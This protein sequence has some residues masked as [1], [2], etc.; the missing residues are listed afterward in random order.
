M[1]GDSTR[2]WGG[3][4]GAL[5]LDRRFAIAGSVVTLIGMIAV[6]A[7]VNRQIEIGVTRNSAIST[8]IYMESFIA[9]LSQELAHANTLAPETVAQ[10]GQLF[11]SPPLSGRIVSAKIWKPGGLVVFASD[12]ELIGERF[13]PTESLKKAWGGEISASFD[14]IEDEEAEGE[15]AIGL[16]LL[17][18]YNPI[19]SILTGEI[20]AVAEFYQ[21]AV[22]LKEDLFMAQLKSWGVVG[23]VTLLTFAALFGIVRNG[24][25]TIEAQNRELQHRLA[26]VD[27]MSAQNDVLRRRI[28]AASQRAAETNERVMRRLSAELHDGPAQ[29]MALA[30]LRLESLA[31]R[32]GAGAD[33]PDNAELRRSLDE[34][35]RDIRHICRGMTL[36]ELEGRTLAE[37]LQSAIT[38][39]ERRTDTRVSRTFTGADIALPHATLI[40]AYRFVQEGLMNAFRHAG[41]AAQSVSCLVA[42]D[43]LTLTVSDGGE[44]FDTKDGAEGGGLGLS[45]LKERVEASGGEFHIAT[46]A[47]GTTLTMMLNLEAVS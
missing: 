3:R 36:P 1:D 17:E 6:G 40:C 4:L 31:R 13:A 42:G 35:M 18:V 21:N 22:A 14:D 15:R 7:W 8:A 47:D 24:S 19:H 41:A 44:G 30:S 32:A 45:G 26:E 16:P 37:A 29:A 33:D 23:G 39:H 11:A 5:S 9:P 34:A 38:A 46:G 10:L 25:L 20:I 43:E 27:R 12:P 28:Q 2:G